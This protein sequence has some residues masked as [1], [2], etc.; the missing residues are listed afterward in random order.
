[1]RWKVKARIQNLVARLPAGLNDRAYYLIQRKVG[2]LRRVDPTSR[3]KG[4][5]LTV[6]YL[7][8]A[9][10]V[11]DSGT[12]LEVG[13]GH[14]LNFAIGLWLCG[15]SRVVTIDLN[16][17]LKPS[18]VWKDIA[19]VRKNESQV[20]ALF[21]EL[22]QRACFQERLAKLLD[23]PAD[24]DRLLSMMNVS[25]LAPADAGSLNLES[26]S[27]DY[28]V[29]YTVLEHIPPD[30]LRQVLR[31]GARVLVPD[32]LFVHFVD[33]S[34]HF[35]QADD[36]IASINFLRFSAQ[37][38]SRYAG[39][40]YMYHNRLRL[41]D[42]QQILSSSGLKIMRVDAVVDRKALQSLRSGFP[43]DTRF[44]T[45]SP[46]INATASAWL[47]AGRECSP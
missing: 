9:G 30:D 12:F 14:Q 47:V 1:M 16:R 32:G 22:A 27:V 46:E 36:S 15:A 35:S 45:I 20:C 39:N 6:R 38:W 10:R 29:S 24:F 23:C 7:S 17:Y 25:Y 42:F 19:F 11:A 33:L 43:L 28:H 34:D 13:T 44:R 4:A 2:S 5:I 21:G 8:E 18:L 41:D 40:R 31:E 3:L 26:Q 37:V